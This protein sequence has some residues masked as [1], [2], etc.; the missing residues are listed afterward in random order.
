MI[1][2]AALAP[3]APIAGA[4]QV[5][6]T[7]Q[8]GAAQLPAPPAVG[9]GPVA[10]IPAAPV[11]AATPAAKSAAPAARKQ[12]PAS[13]PRIAL[14][15]AAPATVKLAEPFNVQINEAGAKN[16]SSSVYLVTYDPKILEVQ[17][18]AEGPFMRQ[19]GALTRFQ[20][21]ADKRKG[22]VW[23]S[24]SLAAEGAGTSGNGCLA[25]ITFQ[26]IGPGKATIGLVKANF[27]NPAGDPFNVNSPKTVVE[28]K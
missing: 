21:V 4:A 9:S 19:K 3:V 11:A 26:A 15:I 13:A 28:V 16:L 22:E 8:T 23:I 10:V 5:P 17:T 1:P 24:L 7:P 18:Q 2:G 12:I 14:S 27:T 20:S 25:T 6:A